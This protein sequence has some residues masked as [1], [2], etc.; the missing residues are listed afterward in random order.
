M[1]H[2]MILFGA[3]MSHI[4]MF[5]K[6]HDVQVVFKLKQANL[7]DGCVFTPEPFDLED[8]IAPEH[9]RDAPSREQPR[10]GGMMQIQT[11]RIGAEGGG[12]EP[13]AVGKALTVV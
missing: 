13:G 4:P 7:C 10:D 3:F 12:D 6:P 1:I 2:E 9:M 8:A 5:H 11:A